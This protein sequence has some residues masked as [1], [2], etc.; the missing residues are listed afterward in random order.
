[1]KTGNSCEWIKVLEIPITP[2]LENPVHIPVI[3][4]SLTIA[5]ELHQATSLI[6]PSTVR[7]D[8][9]RVFL[10]S[11]RETLSNPYPA[12]SGAPAV[13]NA[14]TRPTASS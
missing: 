2:W 4:L 14:S 9:Y 1:M 10:I 6:D 11:G 3:D 13:L 8:S 5:G 12:Q 7:N